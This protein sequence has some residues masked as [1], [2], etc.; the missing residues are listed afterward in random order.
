MTQEDTNL[1]IDAAIADRA[2]EAAEA[3]I[4]RL[5]LAWLECERLKQQAEIYK[6]FARHRERICKDPAYK[7]RVESRVRLPSC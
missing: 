7:G 3:A 6:F 2:K 5:R 1:M 4:D